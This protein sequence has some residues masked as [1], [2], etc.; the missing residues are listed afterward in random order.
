MYTDGLF[1]PSILV[2]F[3]EYPYYTIQT[4]LCFSWALLLQLESPESP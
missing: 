4:D 1:M 2:L 3:W